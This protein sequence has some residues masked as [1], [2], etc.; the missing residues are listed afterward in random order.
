MF[1]ILYVIQIVFLPIIMFLCG[2]ILFSQSWR[3]YP[4]LQFEQFLLTGVIIC[5]ITK[6]IYRDFI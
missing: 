5:I 2:F 3:L 1:L 6:D 4:I